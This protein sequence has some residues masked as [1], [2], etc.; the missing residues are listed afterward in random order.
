MKYD[1]I[2]NVAFMLLIKCHRKRSSYL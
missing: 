2:E 1:W